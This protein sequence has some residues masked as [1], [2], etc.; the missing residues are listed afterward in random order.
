MRSFNIVLAAVFVLTL[1]PGVSV[2]AD[3]NGI[4][5]LGYTMIDEEAGDLSVIQESYN[6]YEKFGITEFSLN[7]SV[8]P[9]S[10]LSLT[11][12]NINLDN[13]A[14]G[15]QYRI[16][17]QV[18]F[19]AAFDQHRQVFDASR[20]TVS[21]RK[22]ARFSIDVTPSALFGMTVSYGI[23]G[24]TGD[25]TSYPADVDGILGRSYDYLLQTGRIEGRTQ[26][27]PRVFAAAIDFSDFSNEAAHTTDRQ[28]RVYSVRAFSPCFFTDK[29]TH[30]L[31]AAYG[32][33]EISRLGLDYTLM[34][35]QY[36]GNYRPRK[37]FDLKYTFFANRIDDEATDMPTDN[38]RHSVDAEYR[39]R[40]ASVFGG[41]S[42]ERNDDDRTLTNYDVYR[43]GGSVNYRGKLSARVRYTNRTK[44]DEENRTLLK[45][46]ETQSFSG[47]ISVT[48]IEN[49]T[50]G[51]R[52][53][54]RNRELPDIGV[55]ID[56][57]TF[58]TFASYSLTNWGSLRADYTYAKNRYDDRIG[59]YKTLNNTVTSR[60][61]IDYFKNLTLSG[62]LAYIDIGKDLD[63]EKSTLFFAS[64][65]TFEDNVH[66]ELKYDVYN[67]DD[68]VVRDR[69]YT[70]NVVW[71]TVGYSF[72]V[73]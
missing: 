10:Y 62:G 70:A 8:T 47:Q 43:I 26:L 13:R 2:C 67:F 60:V 40:F 36:I 20:A 73:Q 7:G 54:N 61:Q 30:S 19:R 23:Q 17:G 50:V 4:L 6:L 31:R 5:A 64:S 37:Q 27:G 45:D 15:I 69:Y 52:Y 51:G 16:P 14:A 48:P 29:L 24:R 55:E 66:I 42:Y 33:H 1:V 18:N 38:F 39:Y 44:Q 11:L 22:H 72:R 57:K 41:Y 49:L 63:I 28:G 34:N 58:S 46:S 56:G 35:F 53:A 3:L 68:F 71:I 12:S 9:R 32:T 59:T 25:R 21:S 65:Y